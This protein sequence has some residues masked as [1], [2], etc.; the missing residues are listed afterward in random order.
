MPGTKFRKLLLWTKWN[1]CRCLMF[2][3][4]WGSA[5]AVL[6]LLLA[7]H[8]KSKSAHLSTAHRKRTFVRSFVGMNVLKGEA[9][10]HQHRTMLLCLPRRVS[11]V[12]LYI[13]TEFSSEC[14]IVARFGRT[15]QAW[16]FSSGW[17]YLTDINCSKESP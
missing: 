14:G 3:L 15:A 10:S 7:S 8:I 16:Q 17:Q 5:L 11:V 2:L 6:L 9:R 1:R 4:F 12:C 13:R